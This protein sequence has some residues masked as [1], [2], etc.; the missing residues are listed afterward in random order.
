M[1]I[2]RRLQLAELAKMVNEILIKLCQSKPNFKPK[3]N[4]KGYTVVKPQLFLQWLKILPKE[5]AAH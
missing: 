3:L 5:V 4:S 1:S 2:P